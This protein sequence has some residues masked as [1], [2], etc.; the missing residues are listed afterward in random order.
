MAT[1]GTTLTEDQYRAA[2]DRGVPADEARLLN[3]LPQDINSLIAPY[4]AYDTTGSPPT[5]QRIANNIFVPELEP[6]WRGRS[7]SLRQERARLLFRRHYASNDFFACR[8]C[9]YRGDIDWEWAYQAATAIM[10]ETLPLFAG[11]RAANDPT[12]FRPFKLDLFQA[13]YLKF[14]VLYPKL[15]ELMFQTPSD[16][17]VAIARGIMDRFN[18]NHQLDNDFT[19]V[20]AI[21]LAVDDND[22]PRAV[23]TGV[24]LM[25]E[26]GDVPLADFFNDSGLMSYSYYLYPISAMGVDRALITDFTGITTAAMYTDDLDKLR[27]E[28]RQQHPLHSYA[29]IEVEVQNFIDNTSGIILMG[30]LINVFEYYMERLS[31][32]LARKNAIDRMVSGN[33][34]I[35]NLSPQFT[36]RV[37]NRLADQY[38]FKLFDGTQLDYRMRLCCP[39]DLLFKLID[40]TKYLGPFDFVSKHSLYPKKELR[41]VYNWWPGSREQDCINLSAFFATTLVLPVGDI[42]TL[43]TLIGDQITAKAHPFSQETQMKPKYGIE[44]FDEDGLNPTTLDGYI[45]L[46]T[47]LPIERITEPTFRRFFNYVFGLTLIRRRMPI[48]VRSMY[49]IFLVYYYNLNRLPVVP[50]R[51]YTRTTKLTKF[52]DLTYEPYTLNYLPDT[53]SVTVEKNKKNYTSRVI[54]NIRID[55]EIPAPDIALNYLYVLKPV[56]HVRLVMINKTGE[57]STSIGGATSFTTNYPEVTSVDLTPIAEGIY[58]QRPNTTAT[59]E[60]VDPLYFVDFDIADV[61]W[62][63]AQLNNYIDVT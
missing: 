36:H 19:A 30:D 17:I 7:R 59:I 11:I 34:I 25:L 2:L 14:D 42:N 62:F 31:T 41:L 47:L 1:A 40:P 49:V 35:E 45:F 33:N 51:V 28:L 13:K 24:R 27:F 60:A 12:N 58:V 26:V 52:Y 20:A 10:S 5:Q 6:L 53:I 44:G 46:R 57:V 61:E 23:E 9:D 16:E 29:A 39:R 56:S 21:E 37:L 4:V 18:D 38:K 54:N 43:T 55:V 3:Y 8:Y 32:P 63:A 50:F 48:T 15:A 22:D